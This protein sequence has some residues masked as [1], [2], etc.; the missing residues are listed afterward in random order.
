MNP[1]AITLAALVVAWLVG[2]TLWLWRQSK[3]SMGY[4]VASNQRFN[5]L[6]GMLREMGVQVGWDDGKAK[7]QVWTHDEQWRL[8][9]ETG[10]R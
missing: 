1:L 3:A 6:M 7:T 5:D 4:Q 2:L 9:K 10:P 8:R